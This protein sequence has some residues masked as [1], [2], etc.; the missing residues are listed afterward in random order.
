MPAKWPFQSLS[1]K[2]KGY[3]ESPKSIQRFMMKD[4][5]IL[6]HLSSLELLLIHS[7]TS[8]EP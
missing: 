3:Q 6:L 5:M 1:G 7:Y 4:E 8:F 2:E